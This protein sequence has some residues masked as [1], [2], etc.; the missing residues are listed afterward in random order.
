MCPLVT[1]RKFKGHHMLLI[2]ERH[3]DCT[4]KI[5]RNVQYTLFILC[6][7]KS[8][9]LTR[10]ASFL[11]QL[12]LGTLWSLLCSITT[13]GSLCHTCANSLHRV[14]SRTYYSNNAL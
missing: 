6:E 2:Y 12:S 9:G 5:L 10:A 1:G 14:Q 4:S 7:I 13:T 11:L 3:S 8:N